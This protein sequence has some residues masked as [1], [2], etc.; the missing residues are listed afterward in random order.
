MWVVRSGASISRWAKT[1]A[2]STRPSG[3]GARG[4][5]QRQ[6]RKRRAR[7]SCEWVAPARHRSA[8]SRPGRGL[9]AR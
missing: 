4:P 1:C 5:H 2:S 3:S 8:S 7:S 6:G 9:R